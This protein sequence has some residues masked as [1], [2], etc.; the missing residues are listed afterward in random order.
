MMEKKFKLLESK[1]NKLQIKLGEALVNK[2]S[3]A[4]TETYKTEIEEIISDQTG[5]SVQITKL[6]EY[7]LENQVSV[8]GYSYLT[9]L[10]SEKFEDN[11]WVP[12]WDSYETYL[13]TDEKLINQ[14]S[15]Y[16]LL[17]TKDELD[18]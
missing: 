5:I 9:Y 10:I 8:Y 4:E 1:K 11:N 2:A 13:D 7:S 14:L 17:V 18:I 3:D 12:V 16:V 15:F 6:I